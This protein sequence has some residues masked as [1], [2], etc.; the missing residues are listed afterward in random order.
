L[1]IYKSAPFGLEGL[2]TNSLLT[3]D[4]LLRSK[5]DGTKIAAMGFDGANAMKALVRELR[6]DVGPNAI[7]VHCFAHC[8]ELIV[9]DA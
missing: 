6:A 9:K 3:K 7:Y 4:I 5:L 1:I 2:S 8:N